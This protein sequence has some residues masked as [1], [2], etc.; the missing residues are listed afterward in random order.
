MKDTRGTAVPEL[1]SV[2][3]AARLANVSPPTIYRA[4][5]RGEVRAVRV[6]EEAGPLQIDREAFIEWLLGPRGEAA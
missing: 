4:V 3:E 2:R 5:W 6:G 1:I